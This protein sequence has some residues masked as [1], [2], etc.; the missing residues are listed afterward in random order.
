MWTCLTKLQLM[1]CKSES[2]SNQYVVVVEQRWGNDGLV[3]SQHPVAGG[4]A[5][6]VV[7][8]GLARKTEW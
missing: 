1:W 6:S 4:A 8:W 5:A 7:T 2:L 3:P